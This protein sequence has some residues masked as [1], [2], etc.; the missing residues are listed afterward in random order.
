MLKTHGI[1]Y[2]VNCTGNIPNYHE[3]KLEYLRFEVA[4]WMSRPIGEHKQVAAFFAPVFDFI[5]TAVHQGDSVLVHCLAGAHRAGTTGVASLMY[6]ARMSSAQ[7]AIIAAKTMR[8]VIEPSETLFIFVF[9]FE[10][11]SF[12]SIVY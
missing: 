8:P 2:V 10:F 7:Q 6:F 11:L 12:A 5:R 4:N 9:E 3:G 1:K